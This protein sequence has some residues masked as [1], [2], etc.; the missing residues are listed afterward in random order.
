M[1]DK[2]GWIAAVIMALALNISTGL[3]CYYYAKSQENRDWQTGIEFWKEAALV[4][5]HGTN[6]AM[7]F[8]FV[9]LEEPVVEGG[10]DD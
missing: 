10:K 7:G 6:R 5:Q 2:A 1:T 8:I 3:A 4:N 9:R